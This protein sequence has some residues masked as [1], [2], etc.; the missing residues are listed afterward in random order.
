APTAVMSP[1]SAATAW[2]DMARGPLDP[3]RRA[4]L[5]SVRAV[6][7]PA[8]GGAGQVPRPP[9]APDHGV[10][11]TVQRARTGGRGARRAHARPHGQ[12]PELAA[13]ELRGPR[14]RGRRR[15]LRGRAEPTGV[16]FRARPRRPGV[17]ALRT[18]ALPRP[19]GRD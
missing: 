3:P 8:R 17:A 16:G 18:T 5:A 13:A 1:L 6:R 14:G 9:R 11:V 2:N 15:R 4:A 19:G 7:G 10:D 12:P